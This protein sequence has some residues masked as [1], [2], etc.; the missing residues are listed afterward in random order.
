M[1]VE[2][3]P[4][5]SGDEDPPPM[6]AF[7]PGW[8]LGPGAGCPP[9]FA[10]VPVSELFAQIDRARRQRGTAADGESLAAGFRPRA[11][12]V[13]LQSGSGFESGGAL[14]TSPP[15]G[16]L[17]GLAEAVTRDGG[18]AGLDD[19]ELIGV[20]RA[21]QRIES[22]ASA[23]GLAAVAELAR[24][25]PAPGTPPA[26][27]GEFPAE[28][29]EFLSDEAAAALPLTG[30]AASRHTELGLDLAARLPATFRAHHQGLIDRARARLIAEATRVL[31]DAD[32]RAV[33]VRVLAQAGGRPTGQLRA[34]LARAVIA[35]DPEAAARRR[36]EAQLD[37]RGRRWQEDAGTAAPAGCGP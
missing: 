15:G 37:P 21:W 26:A 2:A 24:R 16:T 31:S 3:F 12:L 4:G 9:E 23:G 30:Q 36:E 13:P 14:D 22:W 29:S 20:L 35:A 6:G 32:A 18:L 11:P 10:G 19:D 1:A 28:L 8:Y 34:A 25:R 33:G 7:Q 27:P 17:A 5:P